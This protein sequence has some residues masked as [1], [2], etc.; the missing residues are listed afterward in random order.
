MALIK[1]GQRLSIQRVTRDEY[2][3]IR[4]LGGLEWKYTPELILKND[5]CRMYQ[6]KILTFTN[7]YSFPRNA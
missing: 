2:E 1:K 6:F 3:I 7:L 4:K 5:Y